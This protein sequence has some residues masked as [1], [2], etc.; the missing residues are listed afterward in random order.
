MGVGLVA[1]VLFTVLSW[2]FSLESYTFADSGCWELHL[3]AIIG[4]L[5]LDTNRWLYFSWFTER[6][7]HYE[8]CQCIFPPNNVPVMEWWRIIGGPLGW[9]CVGK[10]VFS[11]IWLCLV[12]G[13]NLDLCILVG[14]TTSRFSDCWT[15]FFVLHQ[16]INDWK[17]TA[18]DPSLSHTLA[19]TYAIW[20]AIV[21]PHLDVCPF[22]CNLIWIESCPYRSFRQLSRHQLVQA[23]QATD[24][25]LFLL[26][27]RNNCEF[28]F[29]DLKTAKH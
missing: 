18:T 6:C 4:L 7:R 13:L 28:C 19:P 24:R 25:S 16:E 10:E 5:T 23:H 11:S 29:G 21:G 1:S 20:P 2:F 9:G 15:T 17:M 3:I 8:F 26:A 22:P 27:A 12:L 14:E